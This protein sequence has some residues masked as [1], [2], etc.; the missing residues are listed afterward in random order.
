MCICI[1][2]FSACEGQKKESDPLKLGLFEVT[3]HLLWVLG[4]EFGS[5]TRA[6]HALNC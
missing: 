6:A 3:S 1:C 2:E 5:Y 4:T